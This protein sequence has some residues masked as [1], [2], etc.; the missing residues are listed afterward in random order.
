MRTEE[1]LTPLSFLRR[2]AAMFAD[3][4]AV[5]DGDRRLSYAEFDRRVAGMA[6]LLAARGVRKGDR[7]AVLSPNSPMLL[8]AHY[9]V[10]LSGAILVAL[11]MRL[12]S[13]ELRYILD[14]AGVRLLLFDAEL[15]GLADESALP[16]VGRIS[17]D[18]YE[19][20]LAA[21]TAIESDLDDE[22]APLA[23]NYTSG[24]T[25]RPK[26]AIY[27]HRGAYL[28]ALA[29]AAHTAMSSNTV[30]LWTLPMYHCNGWCFTWAVTAVGGCHV[31]MRRVEPE[32]I[33][34]ALERE[35]ITSMNAAPTVLSDLAWYPAAQRLPHVIKVGT[36]GAPPAPALLARLGELGLDV[37]HL[38]GL[39][40]T[41]GPAVICDWQAEWDELALPAQ[42]K[43]KARQGNVNI[44]GG[45]LRVVDDQGVEISADGRTVGEIQLR[46]N[47]VMRGYFGDEEATARAFMDGWF[48]TGDLGTLHP[49]GYVELRDRVKDVIVSGGENISS[50]EV[51]QAIAEHPSV[52]EVAVVSAPHPRWGEVPVAFITPQP[53]HEPS[54]Q[55]IVEHCRARLAGFKAPKEVVFGALPKTATGKIRKVELRETK[56]AGHDRRVG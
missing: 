49:D 39:T 19:S 14:D 44:L 46:G 38:Y 23:I 16:G 28:Q 10:P 40:E 41:F 45:R 17:S 27:H 12:S 21:S 51:E 54:E 15:A 8:E 6:G 33:W 9:G 3:R 30:H 50:V 32:V 34:R 36:G 26:G 29:M 1:V 13:R 4:P 25:G 31:C 5:V 18:E 48:R 7:V 37:T 24:T 42:A 55:E 22:W 53:G 56:W 35:R 2:S 52:L 11:N 47:N 43:L 20:S